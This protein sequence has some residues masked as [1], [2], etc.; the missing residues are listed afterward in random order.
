MLKQ[1]SMIILLVTLT[2]VSAQTPATDNHKTLSKI[3]KYIYGKQFKRSLSKALDR[4][5]TNIVKMLKRSS[6]IK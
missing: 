2:A 6:D 3:R 5:N 1:W 4:R